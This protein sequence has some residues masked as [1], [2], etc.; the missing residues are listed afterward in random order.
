MA[1]SIVGSNG[2]VAEA[3]TEK[4]A[5]LAARTLVM[6]DGNESATVYDFAGRWI[7]DGEIDEFGRYIFR[8]TQGRCRS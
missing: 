8:S 5:L 7:G 1:W 4:G 6:D 2:D 3:T